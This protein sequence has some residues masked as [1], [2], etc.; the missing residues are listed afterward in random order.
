[1]VGIVLNRTTV[2]GNEQNPRIIW[3]ELQKF[4]SHLV[5]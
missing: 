2:T 3:C 5:T 4:H 1:M